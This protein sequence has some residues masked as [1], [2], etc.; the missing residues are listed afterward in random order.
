VSIESKNIELY[1]IGFLFLYL[2]WLIYH[3][4][5]YYKGEKRK[6]KHLHRFAKEGEVES[7][8]KLAQRYEKGDMV[9]KDCE[10]AAFW[11]QNAAFNGDEKSKEQLRKFLDKR[12]SL[13]YLKM[14]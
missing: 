9:I 3:T 6:I 13:K 1:G 8:T 7:Q 5:R 2:I 10:R 14:K 4:I 11:Y 12:E